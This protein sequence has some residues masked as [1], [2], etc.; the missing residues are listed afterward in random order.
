[1]ALPDRDPLSGQDASGRPVPT[2]GATLA[3]PQVLRWTRSILADAVWVDAIVPTITIR[4]VVLVMAVFAVVVFRPEAYQSAD[5]ILGIWN[6]W[7]APHFIEVATKGYGP[8]ADP[9]R[10]VL[11]PLFPELIAVGSS[12]VPPLTAGMLIS[13]LA[14][15]GAAAGLYRLARFDWDRRTARTAVL[16]M[17]L[18]P[19]GFAFVAAYS[20]APFLV[21]VVWSIVASRM[22]RWPLAGVLGFLAAATRLQGVFLF[23]ALLA[24]YWL[25]RREVRRGVLWLGLV[26]LG[27]LLYIAINAAVF[28]DPLRFVEV[29]RVT[30]SVTNIAPWDAFRALVSGVQNGTRNEFWM[31]VYV[32]PLVAEIVLAA[33]G[34]WALA[35]WRRRPAEAV[36]AALTFVSLSTLSWPIS[37]PR[38]ILGVP[39]VF[40]GAAVAAR[41]IPGG[42][43][44]LVLSTMLF[45]VFVILFVIG[46]WAF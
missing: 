10:I 22:E 12:L 28:G 39:A 21:F 23:P 34:L 14:S 19:T 4:V 18:S 29:Q 44:L 25:E 40:T 15:V 1:V 20:E 42:S 37:L 46:H 9:A 45:T 38:Y 30:F 13:F 8:P 36:Y 5:P 24:A 35:A 16:F 3:T 33:S 2:E 7:D 32:A 26:P 6:Q 43:A 11:F 31:T 41:R 27:L 17:N